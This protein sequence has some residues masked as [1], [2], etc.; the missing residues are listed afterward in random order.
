MNKNG[1]AVLFAGIGV[2][3]WIWPTFNGI[4]FEPSQVSVGEGRIIA[5]IFI[6]GAAN[7]KNSCRQNSFAEVAGGSWNKSCFESHVRFSY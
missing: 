1:V 6:V 4:L 2:A 7:K 5:A 3:S